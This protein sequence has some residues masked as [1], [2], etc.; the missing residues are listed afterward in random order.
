VLEKYSAAAHSASLAFVRRSKGDGV[1]VWAIDDKRF[2]GSLCCTGD[3][4]RGASMHSAS[5]NGIDSFW[6]A[7][8][9]YYMIYT[10]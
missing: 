1:L 6:L 9:E 2:A 3:K 10:P 7:S 8:Q 5:K 4:I